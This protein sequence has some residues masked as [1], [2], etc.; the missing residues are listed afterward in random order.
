MNKDEALQKAKLD[1]INNNDKDKML[2]Y[3]W[4]NMIL[5]GNADTIKLQ[6]TDKYIYTWLA[7]GAI[8]M[9]IGVIF[10]L[11]RKNHKARNYNN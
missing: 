9:C 1:F 8:V 7:I 5:I 11:K 4:A 3:Y 6:S 2:P 10:L